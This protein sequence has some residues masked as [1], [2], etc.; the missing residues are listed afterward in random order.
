MVAT[1]IIEAGCDGAT[2]CAFD[3]AALPFDFDT[4]AA[5]DPVGLMEALQR[6]QRFW[7]GG[8]GGDGRFV[9]HVHV[10]EAAPKCPGRRAHEATFDAFAMPSGA[11]WICGAEYAASDPR[12]GSALTPLGGLGRY[13]MGGCVPL[14]PG[15]HCMKITRV[16]RT[17]DDDAAIA[18]RASALS[19]IAVTVCAL[20]GLAATL[21]SLVL[22]L[23][24]LVKGWQSLAARELFAKGWQ[25][26][27]V[28]A[29]IAVIGAL[30]FALGRWLLRLDAGNSNTMAQRA[31]TAERRRQFPDYLVEITTDKG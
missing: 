2:L 22:V 7:I 11:L 20:G 25:V 10:D 26:F 21:A 29:V 4:A 13:A 31:A 27:P 28:A 5:D 9:F 15:A 14:P 18:S 23:G 16:T 1:L 12:A 8:T 30:V 3:P 17:A 19:I 24:L 6:E